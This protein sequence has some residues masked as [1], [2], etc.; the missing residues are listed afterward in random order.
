MA[1]S[2][3]RV[4]RLSVIAAA[5]S[6]VFVACATQPMPDAAN[7]PGFWLGLVHGFTMLFALVG[8]LFTNYRIY[9]FPNSGGF[10]DLG[11]G[12]GAAS[13]LG[14]SGAAAG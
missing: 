14:G 10:Y 12:I 7:P 13:A 2:S 11:F 1:G 3:R 8:E 9:A 4:A 6:L 5:M